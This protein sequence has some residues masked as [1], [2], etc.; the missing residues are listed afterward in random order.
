MELN[1][2]GKTVVVTAAGG[3]ICGAV[4]REF[5]REGAKVAVWDISREGAER[6]VTEIRDS[7]GEAV[8]VEVDGTDPDQIDRALA[9]TIETFSVPQILVNG[10]GGS[11]PRTTTSKEQTFFDI[12]PEAMLDIVKL[13]YQSAVLASQRI[14]RHMAAAGKGSIVNIS[15]VA[16]I[17]PLSKALTYSDGKAALI[18]F[19]RWL[20][21]ELAASHGDTIRVNSVAPGFVLTEQNRFLLVDSEAGEPTARGRT[22]LRQVPMQRYGNPEEIAPM[23]L[24][25]ASEQASF[26]TGGVFPVDG[27]FTAFAGV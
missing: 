9:R 26:I 7:G 27:G 14:G 3:A 6:T 13:N 20:A 15:S 8:A 5:A 1:L 21:V 19:T 25:L 2:S 22:V 11:S 12:E 17:L 10:T 18:S 4:A 16:G 23:V 24:F